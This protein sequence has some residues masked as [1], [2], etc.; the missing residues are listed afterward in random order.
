MGCDLNVGRKKISGE[1]SEWNALVMFSPAS[2][3]SKKFQKTYFGPEFLR[4]KVHI[5]VSLETLLCIIRH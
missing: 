1:Q 2:K 4:M 5:S 3:D